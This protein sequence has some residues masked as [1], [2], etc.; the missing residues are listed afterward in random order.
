MRALSSVRF[1]SAFSGAFGISAPASRAVLSS[2]KR[3]AICTWRLNGSMSGIMRVPT[4][5][6]SSTFLAAAQAWALSRTFE[7]A[8]SWRSIDGYRCGIHTESHL[9]ILWLS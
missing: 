7:I 2:A 5:T 6:A 9:D 8:V 1:F 3:Q 4:R